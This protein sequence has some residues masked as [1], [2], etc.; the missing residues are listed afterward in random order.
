MS[1]TEY[2]LF[3]KILTDAY[4]Q[5]NTFPIQIAKANFEQLLK[6]QVI[7]DTLIQSF[8][9]YVKKKSLERALRGDAITEKETNSLWEMFIDCNFI[10]VPTIANITEITLTAAN[11]AFIQKVFLALT[12]IRKRLGSFCDEFSVVQTD[13]LWNP[14]KPTTANCLSYFNFDEAI[15]T[16]EKKGP[17]S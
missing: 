8:K 7:N 9:S 1:E 16:A 12:K 5:S 3:G 4:I 17:L 2:E 14:F 11:F 10:I 13:L 6:G 15:S